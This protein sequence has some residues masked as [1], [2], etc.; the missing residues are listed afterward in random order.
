MELLPVRLHNWPH[1]RGA[2]GWLIPHDDPL[3]W[4]VV[5]KVHARYVAPREEVAEY[6]ALLGMV[7]PQMK[8]LM[9][10]RA[11]LVDLDGRATGLNARERVLLHQRP[12]RPAWWFLREVSAEDLGR[13]ER[14]RQE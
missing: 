8:R 6:D 5:T 10:L 3:V 4:W 2:G 14:F 1:D 7:V 13:M 11:Y 12:E 9:T